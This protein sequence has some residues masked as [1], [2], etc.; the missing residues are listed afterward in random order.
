MPSAIVCR[1][2]DLNVDISDQDAEDF[3]S[4]LTY[5]HKNMSDEICDIDEISLAKSEG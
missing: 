2:P 1:N 5:D 3:V 4:V